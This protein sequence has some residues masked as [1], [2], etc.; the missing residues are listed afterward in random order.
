MTLRFSKKE[1]FIVIAIIAFILLLFVSLYFFYLQPLKTSAAQKQQELDSKK[2][3]LV[4]IENRLDGSQTSMFESTEVLQQQIP[5]KP[6]VEQLLLNIE[7]AEVLSGSFVSD[8]KFSDEEITEYT[9]GEQ[10]DSNNDGTQPE[11]AG[12]QKAS[13]SL[14]NGMK[15]VTVTITAQSPTYFEMEKFIQSLESQDRIIIVEELDIT[16]QDE[17]VSTAQEKQLIE[18]KIIVSAFYMPN[19]TDLIGQLPKMEVPKPSNKKNPFISSGN[20]TIQ[21]ESDTELNE[22]E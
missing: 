20:I 4:V 2:K 21:Q 16:G 18:Y 6:L 22:D 17:L 1:K 10:S 5:V 9:T 8:M 14:P 12:E 19:L 11:E 13:F 7:K 3:L 15:K